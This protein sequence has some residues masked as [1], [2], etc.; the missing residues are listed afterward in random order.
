MV[1]RF[2]GSFV[3]W[4]VI[5]LYL[6]PFLE[7]KY[8]GGEDVLTNGSWLILF[9]F[10]IIYWTAGI[11]FIGSKTEEE[12]VDKKSI[13]NSSSDLEL[14]DETKRLMGRLLPFYYYPYN[15]IKERIDFWH[16][17]MRPSDWWYDFTRRELYDEL[18][19]RLKL[20][21]SKIFEV[22][23]RDIVHAELIMKEPIEMFFKDKEK[24]IIAKKKHWNICND[25]I[26]LLLLDV[27]YD[28]ITFFLAKNDR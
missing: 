28:V 20:D 24:I 14:T 3:V 25:T 9:I 16:C 10:S 2:I 23:I 15:E 18:L 19:N 12:T 5:C 8:I 22:G 1:L 17:G 26:E 27:I 7:F 4:V 11:G 13:T 21:H 6:N